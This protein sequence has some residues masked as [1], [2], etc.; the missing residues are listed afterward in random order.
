MLY[1]CAA[2]RYVNT[3]SAYYTAV[4]RP[5]SWRS[6]SSLWVISRRAGLSASAELLVTRLTASIKWY[7]LGVWDLLV[8]GHEHAVGHNDEHDE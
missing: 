4:R 2:C 8:D 5:T 6:F 3:P 7:L 1:D